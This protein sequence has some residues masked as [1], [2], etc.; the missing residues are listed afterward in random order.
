M[1]GTAKYQTGA[2]YPNGGMWVAN[3]PSNVE[4]LSLMWMHKNFDVG[5][6]EKRV[7]QMYNDNGTLNYTIN[8]IQVPY[9]VDQAIT[10]AP[11]NVMNFFA[12]YT[13]KNASWLRGSKLG[14]AINNLAD[15]HSI[16]G[17]TPAVPATATVPYAM[18]PGDQI[19]LL[20][21]RSV[22]ATLTVGWAPRR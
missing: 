4:S 15:N 18:N 9:P 11:F 17:V 19:N 2:N 3:A 13:I 10:I 12:N 21:G 16:V 5:F 6:I 14:L 7:G 20:P 8:G 22:M 1:A